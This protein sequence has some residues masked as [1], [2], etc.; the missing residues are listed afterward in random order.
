MN[1]LDDLFRDGLGA[2]KAEVPND[3]WDKIKAQ[4]PTLPAEGEAIDY[5]F[6][7][8]LAERVAPVP[9]GMW[10]RIAA[11]RGRKT[12]VWRRALAVA[13]AISLLIVGYLT[14]DVSFGE[15][16]VP[17]IAQNA[18]DDPLTADVAAADT[19]NASFSTTVTS[20]PAIT[21]A[22]FAP[23]LTAAVA[24]PVSSAPQP[25]VTAEVIPVTNDAPELPRTTLPAR[26]EVY[27]VVKLPTL[28]DKLA[29]PALTPTP[30]R[31]YRIKPRPGGSFK[32]SPRHR[33]Q[34][35]LLFGVS[36]ANQQFAL[37]S[38]DASL[39]RDAREVSEFPEVGYQV[40]LRQSF[41]IG[42]R[43]RFLGGL[44]YAAIRNQFEY[45]RTINGVSELQQVNNQIRLLEAPLLLGYA[46]PGKG[47]LQVS[48]NAGPIVNLVTATN[49][50]FL[51]PDSPTPLRLNEDG[52]YRG[53]VGLGMMTSL[54]TTY[55]IGKKE[56][57]LLVVE[58]FFKGYLES[59]T[60]G[61]A[62]LREQYWVA[63]MQLGVR[64]A[65]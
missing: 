64:K 55:L 30:K 57:F 12:F 46:M 4:K 65:F 36:Y 7:D 14:I 52:Q 53:N 18:T 15:Q 31:H 45:E 9:A 63:G 17:L 35:E 1:P 11:A 24:D 5:F 27:Q 48:L 21:E 19:E 59:F 58:P 2:R 60:Q 32:A 40:T 20:Q 16:T 29:V 22:G 33:S 10:Q 6:K 56:P 13:A 50:Q 41:R 43:F 49:G 47:R 61:D 62:P 8:K 51:D 34:T 37:N 23:G 25:A 26:A 38:P 44:T 54:T 28:T 3:L 39:L 42:K